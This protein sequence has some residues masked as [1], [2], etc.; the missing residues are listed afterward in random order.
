MDHLPQSVGA[1]VDVAKPSRKAADDTLHIRVGTRVVPVLRQWSTGFAVAADQAALLPGRIDLYAG[2]Q[3]LLQ[4]LILTSREESGERLFEYKF[5]TH[6]S[7][8]AP[9][10]DFAQTEGVSTDEALSERRINGALPAL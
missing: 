9:L 2:A 6:A 8:T 7:E 3:H 5:A 4:A 10:A 1:G